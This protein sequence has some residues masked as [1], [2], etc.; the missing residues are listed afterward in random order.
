MRWALA[1]P[2]ITND[3]IDQ[4]YWLD[5]YLAETTTHQ[6][7]FIPRSKELAKFSARR[8]KYTSVAE[9]VDYWQHGQQAWHSECGGIITGFPQMPAVF[10]AHKKFPLGKKKPVVAWCFAIGNLSTGLRQSLSQWSLHDID[11]F[12]VVTERERKIYSDWLGL[13]IERFQFIPHCDK[14]IPIEWEQE[15]DD[16]F[17]TAQGSAHRD[18]ETFFQA[19]EQSKIKTVLAS[20]KVALEGKELPSTVTAPFGISRQDCWKLNQQSR[21]SVVP[22]MDRPD[23]PAAGI[24]TIVEAML[25]GR[26]VIATRCNGAED[27]IVHGETGFLVEPNSVD[28]LKEAIETL[29]HDDQL[30]EKM[31]LAAKQYA[32]KHFSYQGGA[33][34]LLPILDEL[35]KG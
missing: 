20:S 19:I 6:F 8:S 28:S 27:Y 35:S 14:P 9:W 23:I 7:Q 4:E 18:F 32:D 13:P 12:V 11:R 3:N 17:I 25:M 1:F 10:G 26:P 33:H 30:R 5:K 29:W 34:A 21:F 2:W 24:V 16:P 22:M 31:S 15:V